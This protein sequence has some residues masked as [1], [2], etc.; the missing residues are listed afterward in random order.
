MSPATTSPTLE[1]EGRMSAET[2][3]TPTPEHAVLLANLL[4]RAKP[5]HYAAECGHCGIDELPP[6]ECPTLRFIAEIDAALTSS[7]AY[8]GPT[9]ADC[10]DALRRTRAEKD[11]LKRL[12]KAKRPEL[13]RLRRLVTGLRDYQFNGAEQLRRLTEDAKALLPTDDDLPSIG[14]LGGIMSD[15]AD[16]VEIE[17]KRTQPATTFPEA[18]APTGDQP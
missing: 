14:E 3:R 2:T 5:R 11:R 17:L 7:V 18:T 15:G 6:D 13:E 4:R 16:R 1:L 9:V 12:V 10:L 8:D